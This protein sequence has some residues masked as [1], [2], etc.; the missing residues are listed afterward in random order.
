MLVPS[1]LSQTISTLHSV[2]HLHVVFCAG[3]AGV[4]Q[5]GGLR[6]GGLSGIYKGHDYN[7]GDTNISMY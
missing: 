6:I 3:Y 5:F 7:K 2:N 1:L 4:V